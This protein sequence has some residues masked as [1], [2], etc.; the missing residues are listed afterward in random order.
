MIADDVYWPVSLS[1]DFV[2]HSFANYGNNWN[3]TVS[4]FSIGKMLCATGWKIGYMIGPADL[5]HHV[6]FAVS[7]SC[8]VI[9]VPCQVAIARCLHKVYEPYLGYPDYFTCLRE[10][11]REGRKECLK[12]FASFKNMPLKPTEIEGGFF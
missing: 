12:V 4:T 3:R 1:D 5:I 2:Y 7:A 10:T 8:Q 11:F 9:N 6:C